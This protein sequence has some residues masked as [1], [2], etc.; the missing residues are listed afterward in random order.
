[1]TPKDSTGEFVVGPGPEPPV[2]GRKSREHLAAEL[3]VLEAQFEASVEARRQLQEAQE[4][5]RR[6]EERYRS[7]YH[8]TPVMMQSIDPSGELV[9]VNGYWLR[10]MGYTWDEVKGRKSWDFVTEG[11]RDWVR[12]SLMPRLREHGMVRDAE[13]QF[14]K[15]G[16]EVIDALL[17]AVTQFDDRGQMDYTLAYIQDITQRK[18]AE[19]ERHKLSLERVYLQE[20]IEAEHNFG[21]IVGGSRPIKQLFRDIKRVAGTDST[22][23]I[24]GETGTGKELVARAIHAESSRRD[25][26]LVKVNCAALSAGL[27]ESELFGHEKGAFTGAVARREGRF[28]LADGGSMFLDE[29][30]DLPAELQVKLLRV[31]QEGEFERVGG[32]RSMKVDVRVIAATNRDLERAVEEGRFRSDLYYRLKVY[33]IHVPALRERKEDIPLLVNYL[34]RKYGSKLGKELESVPQGALDALVRYPW[35]GNV[36]ELE[37]VIERAVIVSP[38]AEL[39]LG[40]WMGQALRPGDSDELLPLDEVQRRHILRV[41]EHTGWRVSGPRGAARILGMKPTTL[42]ARMK[43]LGI[44]RHTAI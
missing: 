28:E 5:A 29:I 2:P 1:M 30:G 26:V 39:E 18:R 8:N 16:G 15:K 7:L 22:V 3:R 21:E 33:P 19:E 43:K 40:E 27:I 10:V 44:E 35:P 12:D 38:G 9:S 14:V 24:T 4:S 23:L 32:T 31:L 42:A 20:E 6:S 37:N 25:H 13:L 41:L 17:T 36:R 11:S 34:A